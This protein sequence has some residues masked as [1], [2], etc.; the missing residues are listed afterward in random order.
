MS[1]MQDFSTQ[2]QALMGFP[3]LRWQTRL[4]TQFAAGNIPSACSLPTGLGKTSVIAIWLIALCQGRSRLP[5][6]LVYLVNRRTIVDQATREAEKL[7]DRIAAAPDLQASLM[8]QFG[9]EIDMPLAI[10]T[11]RGQFADNGEWSADPARPAI[12]V[13]TVD[14][15]GSRLLFSGYGRGFKHRPLHAGFLGQ[16]VLLVHDEAHL[17]LAFQK[18]LEEI[19]KE[20]KRC[21]EFRQVH[22]LPLTA[23]PRSEGHRPPFMLADEDMEDKVVKE[24]LEAVKE[25]VLHSLNDEKQTADAVARLAL[26][27]AQANP[28]SSVLVFVRRVEDVKKMVEALRKGKIEARKIEQLTGTLRGLERDGLVKM[29]VFQRFVSSSNREPGITTEPSTVFLVCTSAG[30]VG[31]DISADHL[32]CD[33]S[34]FDSMAQRLG[35]VNRY[36]H[37]N[38]HVDIVHPLTFDDKKEFEVRRQRTLM[39]LQRLGGDGSPKSL[40]KLPVTDRA[41]AFTPAP[42]ILPVS[43]ILFDAWAL[44]TIRDEMPGRPPIA[45][46]LHG[47]PDDWDP[48]ETYVAWRKEVE[49][50]RGPLAETMKPADLL[51]DYPLKPHELLRD[52]TYRVAEELGKLAARDGDQP[53]WIVGDDVVETTTLRDLTQ[54][55]SKRVVARLKDQIVLLPPSA[56]GLQGG[57]LTGNVGVVEGERYDVADEWYQ[58]RARTVRQRQRTWH[59]EADATAPAGMRLVRLIDARPDYG[60]APDDAAAENE[61]APAT[62][63]FWKWWARPRAANDDMSKFAMKEQSLSAHLADA[64]QHAGR[65]AGALGLG[66]NEAKA[67]V[68]AARW[69]DLGKNRAVWQR[70]IGNHAYF[71]QP[72]KI[73]AKSGSSMRPVELGNYRHEFGSLMDIRNSSEFDA[74]ADDVKELVLHLVAAHHG[75]AR[76]HFPAEETFDPG[77]NGEDAAA[78]AGEIPQR[79]ARLQRKYGRWGL[80]YLES[81][82]RAAD[83]LASRPPGDAE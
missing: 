11:L 31:V 30:E 78:L 40:G 39:L 28:D 17:E 66:E 20:Q 69:H 3:P 49:I 74:L 65:M 59:D 26:A 56:G 1:H 14:M 23:T 75:R 83:I 53:V 55:D 60:T 51:D 41:A 36:G 32:V 82:V 7:R 62:P 73:L 4:F 58:D 34:P 44:T 33:L 67:I 54:G 5:R 38:A 76:P 81:L 79:F 61:D 35:R 63:R 12:I 77:G 29:P 21:G 16:D 52:R 6:R 46:W 70:S 45:D 15:I 68:L 80:A 19:E 48:P 72:Q 47:V 8:K 25:I 18:L 42:T 22:V 13:G 27:R 71:E 37:G 64:E 43:D 9:S 2:F 57:M 24:R 10:S 50:I